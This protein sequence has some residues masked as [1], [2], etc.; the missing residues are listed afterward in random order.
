MRNSGLDMVSRH[1]SSNIANWLWLYSHNVPEAG[2]ADIIKVPVKGRKVQASKRGARFLRSQGR[3]KLIRNK[4][5][6][7]L[8]LTRK[9]AAHKR[10]RTRGVA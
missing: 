10:K 8:G 4:A 6:R 1:E 5:R 9:V 7:K 3:N 2:N